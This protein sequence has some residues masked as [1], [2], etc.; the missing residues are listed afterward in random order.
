MAMVNVKLE[1]CTAVLTW[2]QPND[3]NSPILEYKIEVKG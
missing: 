2:L 3:G 1:K